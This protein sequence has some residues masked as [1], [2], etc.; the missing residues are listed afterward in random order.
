MRIN[1]YNSAVLTRLDVLDGFDTVKI[2]TGYK[3]DGKPVDNFPASVTT[4]ERCQATYEELPG[5]D[6]PTACATELKDLPKQALSY[7][8][9]LE[10]LIGCPIS[11]ISTGPRRQETVVVR[12][13]I[14]PITST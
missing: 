3:L 11:I 5:W 12:P 4:L 1:G 7:I 8:K 2:C 13:I 10:E 9:R 14:Q 6:T